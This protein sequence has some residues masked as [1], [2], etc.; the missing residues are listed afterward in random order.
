M[1]G[2]Q[3]AELDVEIHVWSD[4]ARDPTAEVH[5]ELVQARVKK[6]AIDR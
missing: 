4:F 5:A 1:L 3:V 2:V 6:I